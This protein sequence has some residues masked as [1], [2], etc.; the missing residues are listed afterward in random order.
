MHSMMST[1]LIAAA[2]ITAAM[3]VG[4]LRR[5][6]QA[7]TA[8]RSTALAIAVCFSVPVGL[9]IVM[10]L[11]F[12]P[13]SVANFALWLGAMVYFVVIQFGRIAVEMRR[14]RSNFRD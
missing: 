6:A 14:H 10:R 9:G 8:R 2:L 4:H 13:L 5:S 12:I 3:L 7:D 1:A 11:G